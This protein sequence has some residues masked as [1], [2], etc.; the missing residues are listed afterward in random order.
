[1]RYLVIFLLEFGLISY[2]RQ[3]QIYGRWRIVTDSVRMYSDPQWKVYVGQPDDYFVIKED[4]IFIKE[5]HRLD[6]LPYTLNTRDSFV[7]RSGI[8]RGKVES[9]GAHSAKIHLDDN[10]GVFS[11]VHIGIWWRYN[12]SR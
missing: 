1:M 4:S 12:L 5:G 6:T 8:P 7:T 3:P 11:P 10:T 2:A 9:V